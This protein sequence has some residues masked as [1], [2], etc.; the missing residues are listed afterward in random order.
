MTKFLIDNNLSERIVSALPKAFQ[1]S[2]HV[3]SLRLHRESDDVIWR[4]AKNH[5]YCILTKDTDFEAK[6]RLYGCPPKVVQLLVG[7]CTTHQ[8]SSIIERHHLLILKF[9]KSDDDCLLQVTH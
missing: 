8:V 2:D 6:S 3:K 1:F 4:Y 7:N 5:R 9:L